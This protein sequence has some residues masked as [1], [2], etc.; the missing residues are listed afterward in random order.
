MSYASITADHPP[1]LRVRLLTVPLMLSLALAALVDISHDP[2]LR[3]S[4]VAQ[5]QIR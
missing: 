3:Q 4:L 5:F 1:V 2:Q